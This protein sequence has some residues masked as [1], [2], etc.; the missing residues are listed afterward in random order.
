MRPVPGFRLHWA[1]ARTSDP[2]GDCGSNADL[3]V[4][5][6]DLA[7]LATAAGGYGL[8]VR[9]SPMIAIAITE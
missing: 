5:R 3:F 9:H 8:D 6:S 2:D 1:G 4:D 7:N